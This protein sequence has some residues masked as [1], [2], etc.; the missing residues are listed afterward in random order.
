MSARGA[1]PEVESDPDIRERDAKGEEERRETRRTGEMGAAEPGE[2]GSSSSAGSRTGEGDTEE[3]GETDAE[4]AEKPRDNA[5]RRHVP[6]GAWLSQVPRLLGGQV[7]AAG[8]TGNKR[9]HVNRLETLCI[10]PGL[11]LLGN[12][13]PEVR[14]PLAKKVATATMSPCVGSK[15]CLFLC[16]RHGALRIAE[17]VYDKP[18][19]VVG[20]MIAL[21]VM[22]H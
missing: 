15:E 4:N 9:C 12:E 2:R 3:D 11:W 13:V 8:R 10:C 17:F 5:Q 19:H 14:G 21:N 22:I 18:L 1:N 20:S 16:V 6:G 7:P